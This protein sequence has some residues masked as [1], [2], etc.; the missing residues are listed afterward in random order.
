MARQLLYVSRASARRET[1]K[2]WG[3]NDTLYWYHQT[4]T[5]GDDA[6]RNDAVLATARLNKFLDGFMKAYPDCI[7]IW[8]REN[9][10]DKAIHFQVILL[11]YGPRSQSPE[12]LRRKLRGDILRRWTELNGGK[13]EAHA[14]ELTMPPYRARSPFSFGYLTKNVK[15]GAQRTS[16]PKWCG[17]RNAKLLAANSTP[18]NK[19]EVSNAL[20][21]LFIKRPKWRRK[22]ERAIIRKVPATVSLTPTHLELARQ[23]VAEYSDFVSMRGKSLHI[24]ERSRYSPDDCL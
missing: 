8:V 20:K 2:W 1:S 24:D 18:Q 12:T 5:S 9:Q 23:R 10:R 4:L 15:I 17:M 3:A 22:T 14:N 7:P 16:G 6:F 21:L 11:F 13:V 19:R